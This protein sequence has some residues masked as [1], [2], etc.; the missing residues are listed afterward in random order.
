MGCM[1]LGR[2]R[3]THL[4]RQ[5]YFFLGSLKTEATNGKSTRRVTTSNLR[6]GGLSLESVSIE[7][8]DLFELTFLYFF[9][10]QNILGPH[11]AD[12]IS[13]TSDVNRDLGLTRVVEDASGYKL[14]L[15]ARGR[16]LLSEVSVAIEA[17]DYLCSCEFEYMAALWV[18][19]LG[20]EILPRFLASPHRAVRNAALECLRQG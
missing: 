20:V 9:G 4:A 7:L 19:E 15:T 3:L 14:A 12:G 11:T 8:L 10:L 17:V 5:I 6:G 16:E 1:G 18:K 13:S 2:M